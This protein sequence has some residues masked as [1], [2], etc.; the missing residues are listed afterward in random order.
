MVDPEKLTQEAIDRRAVKST[1]EGAAAEYYT[2]Q[3]LNYQ[4]ELDAGKP[5]W[6]TLPGVLMFVFVF[7]L[8]GILAQAVLFYYSQQ[9]RSQ[10]NVCMIGLLVQGPENR[11]PT[12]IPECE[13]LHEDFIVGR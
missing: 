11:D 13:S 3:L 2:H 10:E 12:A 9:S 1:P 4:H 7:L 8:A 5:Y 6:R